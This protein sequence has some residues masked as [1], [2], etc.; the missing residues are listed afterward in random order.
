PM[1]AR[2][3]STE[4]LDAGKSRDRLA[5][6]VVEPQFSPDPMIGI[7]CP[8]TSRLF[9]WISEMKD[10]ATGKDRNRSI[11]A[12]AEPC[13]VNDIPSPGQA[14]V[15]SDCEPLGSQKRPPQARRPPCQECDAPVRVLPSVRLEERRSHWC[16]RQNRQSE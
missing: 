3:S 8:A 9:R 2:P 11:P 7:G 5:R 4:R 6:C 12:L 10:S 16:R 14:W 13:P 1:K 15:K